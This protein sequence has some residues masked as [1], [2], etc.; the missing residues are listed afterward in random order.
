MDLTLPEV[1]TRL[2]LTERQVRYRIREG[3]LT[4]RKKGG[5]WLIREEDLPKSEV[6]RARRGQRIQAAADAVREGAARVEAAETTGAAGPGGAGKGYSIGHLL[7]FQR[8]RELYAAIAEAVGAAARPARLV[9]RSLD[10]MGRGVHTFSTPPKT[11]AFAQA[12][13][14]VA[15]AAVALIVD[16]GTPDALALAAQLEQEVVPRLGGLLRRLEKRGRKGR[17]DAFGRGP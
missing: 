8:G 17:F 16:H 7:A 13:D 15:L 4:A 3:A 1:A 5:R 9:R 14:L 11:A 12:R 10:A 6:T 2:A